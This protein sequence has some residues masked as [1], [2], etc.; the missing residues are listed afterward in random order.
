MTTTPGDPRSSPRR[1]QPGAQ[2][3]AVTR[4]AGAKRTGERRDLD[5]RQRRSAELRSPGDGRTSHNPVTVQG[6]TRIRKRKGPES[7]DP[8]P[9][10]LDDAQAMT[11]KHRRYPHAGLLQGGHPAAGAPRPL[12]REP[13]RAEAED[14]EPRKRSRER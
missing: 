14:R 3:Q 1:L 4:R 2:A 6:T 9:A 5:G 8:G 13:A 11:P 10:S 7:V 12:H